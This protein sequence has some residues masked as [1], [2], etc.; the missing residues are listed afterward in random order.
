LTSPALAASEAGGP[1]PA[2]VAQVRA[3]N[4]FYT[5]VIGLLHGLYLDTP[6]TLTESR[7]LFEIARHGTAGVP[8]LRAALDIDP[9]YLSRVLTRFAA[10]GL[11][12]RHRT[13]A[14]ARR[15][16]VAVTEAGRAAVA[17]L[18]ARAAA[19]IGT[20][21]GG[22]DCGPVLDAMRVITDALG[23]PG[24]PPA[25]GGRAG[26]AVTVRPLRGGDLG[27]ILQ[28][29][30][31]LY[32]DEFGWDASFEGFCARIAGEYAALRDRHPRRTEGWI[33]EVDG[34]PAGS[35][36]CVPDS[37]TPGSG[38][39][40]SGTPGSETTARLRLL[41][42][43]PWARGLG[44]GA[45]LTAQCLEF[46]RQAGYTRIVLLTY[47]QLAAARRVYQAAGFMLDHEHP[48]DAF[49]Q[50]LTAQS[51]SRSL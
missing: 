19:Q 16:E 47:G 29:H 20:L 18:D 44:L 11:V 31:T 35:V 13:A 37:G 46:A 49:G 36:C 42:A 6:Y 12:T 8:A 14:D 33:A 22:V 5:N 45:R 30:G 50:R 39:P 38:T 25:D 10:D 48:E 40:G 51:W 17:E 24:R 7:L 3:F 15:Q 1:T 34:L 4:R 43:E 2:Q 41:I 27:W 23:Q 21:L 32:A 26:R 28:R 9:G